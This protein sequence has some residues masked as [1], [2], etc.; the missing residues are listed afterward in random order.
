[1][2]SMSR[3]RI[4]ISLLRKPTCL[5]FRHLT[6]GVFNKGICIKFGTQVVINFFNNAAMEI[7]LVGS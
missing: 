7:F 1:M 2:G 4:E 6:T 5:F 3:G